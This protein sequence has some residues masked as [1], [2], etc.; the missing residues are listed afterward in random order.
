M[1]FLFPLWTTQL[2]CAFH[3]GDFLSTCN[4]VNLFMM[5][6]LTG[7]I[8]CGKDNLLCL[9]RK[10]HFEIFYQLDALCPMQF[11]RFPCCTGSVTCGKYNWFSDMNK[12]DTKSL[13]QPPSISCLSPTRLIE[14]SRGNIKMFKSA[15]KLQCRPNWFRRWRRGRHNLC[16]VIILFP[17]TDG[18]SRIVRPIRTTSF[19]IKKGRME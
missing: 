16:T 6:S 5:S 14:I 9:A 12:E 8:C 19:I 18:T 15:V 17:S 10:R 3:P 4:A 11:W 7:H 1:D 2:F 13:T